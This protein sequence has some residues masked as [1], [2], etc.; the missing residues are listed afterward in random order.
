MGKAVTTLIVDDSADSRAWLRQR[1]EGLGCIVVGE[2]ESAAEGLERFEALRPRLVTL[3]I[4][5][6]EIDGIAAIDLLQ[7]ITRE[8]H[9]A[10]VLVVSVRPW[11]DAHDYLKLGAIGYLEKP[12]IDFA[13]A[14]GY[15]EL[16]FL[17]SE[18]RRERQKSADCRRVS[19]TNPEFH[20]GGPATLRYRRRG[21]GAAHILSLRQIN[22]EF[23]AWRG[24]GRKEARGCVG[25]LTPVGLASAGW[26]RW[27]S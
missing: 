11:T 8:D 23:P 25:D 22:G 4:V 18:R 16:I 1:L 24:A 20:G 26:L 7:R 6:P 3:D 13:E 17:N 15:S 12:F 10:G 2:A 27:I 21:P 14:P 9:E 5:M 19:P